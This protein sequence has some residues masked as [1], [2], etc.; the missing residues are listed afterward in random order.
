MH[1]RTGST[2]RATAVRGLL[3]LVLA[4]L[5]LAGAGPA[6]HADG[7]SVVATQAERLAAELRR[8]PVYVS[9]DR[10]REY[11]RSL[12][13]EIAR[14][15]HRTGVPTYVLALPAGDR[16]LLARVH[17][18][19]G[20]DGLYVLIGGYG[21]IDAAA[22]GV[23]APAD[24]AA[25]AAL[26]ATPTGAGPLDSFRTFADTVALGPAK[27]E[28]RAAELDRQYQAHGR[29]DAYIDS[30]DR[31]NQNLLLGMGVVLIPGLVLALGLY[32]SRPRGPD[33]RVS[34]GKKP[35]VSLG[36]KQSVSLG[37][38]STGGAGKKKAAAKAPR[39]RGV[40]PATAAATVAALLAVVFAAPTVFPET[41]DG[42]DLHVTRAD[43]DTRV[44]EATAALADSPVYQSSWAPDVLTGADRTAILHR[45][46]A[47]KQTGPVYLVI[48]PSTSD[49]EVGGDAELL[50]ARIH[51]GT[52]HDGVYVLLDPADGRIELATFG[53]G[54]DA[55]SRFMAL[56]TSV[57][58]PDYRRDGD[59]Q[60][61]PRLERTLDAVAASRPDSGY[62]K[63]TPETALP[64]LHDNRLPSLYTSDFGPGLFLGFLGLG[65]LLLVLWPLIA[66]ARRLVRRAR[67]GA[68][69]PGLAAG[70]AAGVPEP[71]HQ[72]AEP[73]ARQ[74]R[75]WAVTDVRALTDRLADTPQDAPDR[76]RAWDC[77][78]AATLLT[79]GER[80]HE[81]AEPGTL[82]AVVLLAGAGIAALDGHTGT[83]LCRLNPLHG[84]ATGGRI[85]A[86][87][88]DRAHLP[89][90][91]KLCLACLTALSGPQ[92][93]SARTQRLLRLPATAGR[94]ARTDWH[95]AGPILPAAA[96]GVT[97]LI[98]RARESASVQ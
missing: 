45:M 34:P 93:A 30:V 52:G 21:S 69:A 29:P 92:A 43:L 20:K 66:L 57:R 79:G 17:D 65:V 95:Q 58:Y 90:S 39:R 96:D 84:G 82:V 37:K 77:L 83:V 18:R 81:D 25:R 31:Q 72:S 46:T 40:L 98:S 14:I 8:T 53:T 85:P 27:A 23:A 9:P 75:N 59:L 5:A 63:E 33:A 87:H 71:W 49:D 42:P 61:R 78:D 62:D 26:Y 13:P 38:K 68:A 94:G 16:T 88:A 47:L 74:L 41:V 48:T 67:S 50:L 15:A 56:P 54:R 11:P 22:F 12:A 73:T 4:V 44:G 6:A 19:L 7:G 1:Q 86:K 24:E 2:G 70:L 80:P 97:A 51:R 55:A 36:K 10:P 89:R 32:L 64:P 35:T 60:V 3:A 76:A 91:A 28:A